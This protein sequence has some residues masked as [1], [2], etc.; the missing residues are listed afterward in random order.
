M[1]RSMDYSI[2]LTE[3]LSHG[4]NLKHV[5]MRVIF[6]GEK[7][8][9]LFPA[10]SVR[11]FIDTCEFDRAVVEAAAAR[12]VVVRN[13]WLSQVYLSS[14]ISTLSAFNKGIASRRRFVSIPKLAGRPRPV[15]SF[16]ATPS[17]Y[18]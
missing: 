6:V 18:L 14:H 9:L 13:R 17:E 10:E 5:Q 2:L 8:R 15:I 16:S 7:N 3:M 11:F 4:A 1:L 12:V